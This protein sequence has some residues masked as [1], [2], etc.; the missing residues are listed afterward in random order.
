MINK[1]CKEIVYFEC[2]G[3]CKY[4]SEQHYSIEYT[5]VGLCSRN[6]N[7]TVITEDYFKVYYNSWCSKFELN[8]N[9]LVDP[10]K[11]KIEV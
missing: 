9:V 6:K 11:I 5:R 4:F 1:E 2:C 3:N 10:K 8:Q 7:N